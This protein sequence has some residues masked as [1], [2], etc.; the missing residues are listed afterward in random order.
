M[1]NPQGRACQISPLSMDSNDSSFLSRYQNM[2]PN[3]SPYGAARPQQ[4]SPPMSQHPSSSTDNSLSSRRSPNASNGHVSS[5]SSL[6]RSSESNSNGMYSPIMSD[7]G[8]SFGGRQEEALNEHYLVLKKY[9]AQYLA[10]EAAAARPTRARDKLLRLSP[11]QFHELSTDVYDELLRR[12][13]D[14]ARRG[15]DVPRYLLPKNTFHPKR[16]QARQKLSTLHPDRFRQLATDV[17]FELERRL[18]LLAGSDI[19]RGT[20]PAMSTAS[21]QRALLG[22]GGPGRPGMRGPPIGLSGA[23]RGPPYDNS[24]FPDRST[25]NEYGRPLPKTFQSNTIVPNK[26]TMIEDYETDEDDDATGLEKVVSGLT[27]RSTDKS[28][29]SEQDRGHI[30][31]YEAQ[32]AELQEKIAL[33]EESVQTKDMEIER[34][35]SSRKEREQDLGTEREESNKARGELERQLSD[36]HSSSGAFQSE[37]DEMHQGHAK[38]T[39]DLRSQMDRTV[40]DMQSQIDALIS[41]NDLLQHQT[42][43]G[44][45]SDWR[46][47]CQDLQDELANQEKVTEDVRQN[48]T[49][50]LQ[51]MRVL[52]EQSEDAVEREEQLR[53]QI[54]T[55]ETEI[56]EWKSRYAMTKTQLR[57]LKASSIGLPLQRMANEALTGRQELL[58]EQGLVNDVDVTNFQISIDELLHT[59]RQGSADATLD[60]MKGVVTH[61]QHILTDGNGTFT[62]F[63]SPG[64][65]DP[66]SPELNGAPPSTAALKS[67]V[68]RS[69]N[70]LITA[71]RNHVSSMGLSPVSL[72]DAAAGNVTAAVVEYLKAVGIKATPG[73]DLQPSMDVDDGYTT[74][75]PTIHVPANGNKA[76]PPRQNPWFNRLK[77]SMDSSYSTDNGLAHLQDDEDEYASYR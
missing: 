37:L 56:E 57:T 55:L 8:R 38:S 51:E 70:S 69:A 33:L 17:F 77:G 74:L 19:D 48:A 20:S 3:D 46:Q 31:A 12:E 29:G 44:G 71:T 9:L 68:S 18:P 23:S 28:S 13:D 40:S 1:M 49:Q 24:Q 65:P 41:E 39:A 67:R 6:T 7:S 45:D 53:S 35:E 5:S 11:T 2:G 22:P 52:S 26:S 64:S 62:G 34:H 36:M 30:K 54:N 25:S 59:A 16:N 63:P 60:K 58:S 10:K 4:K 15:Q 47:R 14:R 27:K 66:M 42:S 21:S 32:I 43:R 61:V 75:A 76:A 50:F 72:L 73:D